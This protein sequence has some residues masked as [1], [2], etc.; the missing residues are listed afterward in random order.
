MAS[1]SRNGP[2]LDN[3]SLTPVL[4]RCGFVETDFVRDV[5]SMPT[6]STNNFHGYALQYSIRNHAEKKDSFAREFSRQLNS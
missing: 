3:G 6:E 4:W 5:L 2:L 1:E